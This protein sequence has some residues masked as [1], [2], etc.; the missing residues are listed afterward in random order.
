MEVFDAVEGGNEMIVCRSN[1]GLF[2]ACLGSFITWSNF[3]AVFSPSL[4]NGLKL[5]VAT[6]KG[7]WQVD[8]ILPRR[9]QGLEIL[10]F[11]LITHGPQSG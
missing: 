10:V 4:L 1:M 7:V 3:N 9:H 6:G 11:G 2:V 5:L 8:K